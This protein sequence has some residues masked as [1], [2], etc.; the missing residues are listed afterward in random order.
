MLCNEFNCV[1]QV[2]GEC[3]QLGTECIGDMCEEYGQCS[4]CQQL[5]REECEGIKSL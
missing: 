2:D 5:D 1:Y 4:G 3:E